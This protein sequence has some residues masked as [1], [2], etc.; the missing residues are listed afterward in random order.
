MAF[1]FKKKI[2]RFKAN[3][4]KL[5]VVIGAAMKRHYLKSFRE[6]GFTDAAFSPWAKRT[7]RNRSDKRNKRTRGLLVDKGHLRRSVRVVR[8]T[9][10]RVEVGSTGIKYAR[11]HNRGEGQP[12]R[13]F[14]GSSRVLNANIGKR[15]RRETKNIFR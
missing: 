15:I 5:P 10:N 2:A 12:K 6:G 1:N 13:M 8:A 14:V 9:W 7:T 11:F 4:K 3:K